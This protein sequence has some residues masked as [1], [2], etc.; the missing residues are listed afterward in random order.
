MKKKDQLSKPTSPLFE[1]A[2]GRD[3][4]KV[5]ALLAAGRDPDEE[6]GPSGQRAILAAAT[7]GDV[8]LVRLLLDARANVDATDKHGNTPLSN[9]V[10]GYRQDEARYTRVI[11]DLLEHGADPDKENRHGVSAR[12]LADTIA[13]SNVKDVLKR[14]IAQAR[15]R[16]SGNT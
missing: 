11:E 10:Y 4:V 3:L 6:D 1:A 13:T 9:A 8:E 2:V 5:K 15:D 16:R 14:A 12:G 7:N